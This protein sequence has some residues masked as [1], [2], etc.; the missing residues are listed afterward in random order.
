MRLVSAFVSV[1]AVAAFTAVGTST[2]AITTATPTAAAA[3]CPGTFQVLHDDRIGALALPAGPYV[4]TTGK[5]VTCAQAVTQFRNFLNDFDGKLPD[6]WVVDAK[7]S[8]FTQTTSGRS[9]SVKPATTPPTPPPPNG[10]TCPGHFTLRHDDKILTMSLPAGN[11]VVQLTDKNAALTCDQADVQFSV[12]LTKNYLTPLPAP[13]TMNAAA[14]SFSRPTGGGFR[15]V[16]S[17]GG[18]GGGGNDGSQCPGTFQVLHNDSIGALKVPAGR[19]TITIVNAL[20][21]P[22]ATNWF[23]TFL[24]APGNRLPSGWKL[25]VQTATFTLRARSFRI[26]PYVR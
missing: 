6:H 17:G 15:V 14:R 21:C 5:D 16:R 18:T 10:K 12:F 4:I 23:K 11:Y 25:N 3:A 24:A 2:A 20:T 13:W 9:F 7:T 26:E 22:S 1:L 8:S 19:Y